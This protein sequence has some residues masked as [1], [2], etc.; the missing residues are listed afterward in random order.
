[1][2][3]VP[4]PPPSLANIGKASTCYTKGRKSKR[5]ERQVAI[6]TVLAVEGYGGSHSTNNSKKL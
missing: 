2:S 4:P 1:M 6:I 3:V 5:V